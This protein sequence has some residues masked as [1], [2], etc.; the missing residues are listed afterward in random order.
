MNGRLSKNRSGVWSKVDSCFCE[1]LYVI[2]L[3]SSMQ[4]DLSMS[5]TLLPCYFTSVFADTQSQC[6]FPII[7]IMIIT[8]VNLSQ[9]FLPFSQKVCLT[10]KI[11]DRYSE[12]I[13]SNVSVQVNKT[14]WICILPCHEHFLW[15]FKSNFCRPR[16]MFK[17]PKRSF[18]VVIVLGVK[19]SSKKVLNR[20]KI[21]H[22]NKN[23]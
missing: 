7:M 18:V 6:F 19:S 13:S 20:T 16:A 3:Q 2:R 9:F 4:F 22:G 8:E 5:H 17:G 23:V 11:F 21:V 10:I 14:A 1:A 15:S 12:I